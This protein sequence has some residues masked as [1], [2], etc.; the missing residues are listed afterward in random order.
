MRMRTPSSVVVSSL[1][2]LFGAAKAIAPP[3]SPQAPQT[4]SFVSQ[5]V[6]DPF[7]EEMDTQRFVQSYA[8]S[9]SLD[10]VVEGG[11][12]VLTSA[13]AKLTADVEMIVTEE[14]D[15]R[16]EF[17]DENGRTILTFEVRN[18]YFHSNVGQ[19]KIDFDSWNVG[20]KKVTMSLDLAY[21]SA[22]KG[23]AVLEVD[24]N[25]VATVSNVL[26]QGGDV[27]SYVYHSAAMTGIEVKLFNSSGE[28]HA[29]GFDFDVDENN[30]VVVSPKTAYAPPSPPLT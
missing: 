16:V 21:G 28:Q 30:N 27:T 10:V 4:Q 17:K 8:S 12:T 13:G 11:M 3:P 22:N 23:D 24:G 7:Y 19:G 26:F 29:S 20:K 2:L 1:L 25:V 9:A 6:P 14:Y 15:E 5:D 18:D